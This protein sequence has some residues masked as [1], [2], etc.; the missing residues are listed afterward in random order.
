VATIEAGGAGG[1]S[2]GDESVGG[3]GEFE[4]LRL[5]CVGGLLG[6]EASFAIGPGSVGWFV[7]AEIFPAH[8]RDAVMAI[9]VTL[10]WLANCSDSAH[11]SHSAHASH[12]HTLWTTSPGP[13]ES[14][15]LAS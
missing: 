1:G 11:N 6:V 15:S 10:N 7:I 8:A 2:A 9:A 5:L 12:L 13:P 14:R 3:G 4:Q